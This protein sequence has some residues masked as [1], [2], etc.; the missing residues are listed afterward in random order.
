MK[1]LKI[2]LILFFTINCN[3]IYAHKDRIEKPKF[4]V[5][6]FGKERI[7]IKSSEKTKLQTYSNLIISKKKKLTS[8]DLVFETNEVVSFEFKD[9]KC[10]NIEIEY[11]KRSLMVPKKEVEKITGVNLASVSLLWFGEK[12]QASNSKYFYLQFSIEKN[13]F[14]YLEIMFEN[15]KFTSLT[16]WNRNENS[17]HSKKL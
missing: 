17:F 1:H 8:F 11:M 12:K 16:K 14:P 15:R 9:Y 5:L 2:I 13:E 10:I 4:Y 6:Y 3:S 7:E